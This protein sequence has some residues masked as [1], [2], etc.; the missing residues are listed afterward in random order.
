MIL[1]Y[2]I[3]PHHNILIIALTLQNAPPQLGLT[4]SQINI[5]QKNAATAT[6]GVRINVLKNGC[7]AFYSYRLL[8][9]II[10]PPY[11]VKYIVTPPSNLT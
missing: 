8:S 11:A 5:T 7:A 6:E 4:V 10:A 2:A 1:P 9:K 3:M